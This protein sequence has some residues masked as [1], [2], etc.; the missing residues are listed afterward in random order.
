M[1]NEELFRVSWHFSMKATKK[2]TKS[3][4]PNVQYIYS[5]G[6]LQILSYIPM[7][8]FCDVIMLHHPHV[9]FTN[10]HKGIYYSKC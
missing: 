3:V 1:N 7:Y 5:V 4:S 10:L 6:I 2:V 8:S 9:L